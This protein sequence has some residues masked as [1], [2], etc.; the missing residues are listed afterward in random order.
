[1][2]LGKS[3]FLSWVLSVELGILGFEEE[4]PPSDSPKSIF[5]GGDPSSTITGIGSAQ[6]L[7]ASGSV[8]GFLWTPLG[9][10][11]KIFYFSKGKNGG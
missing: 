8:S 5:G 6:V 1:M 4:N 11:H 3:S 10:M 2:D 7:W 9:K